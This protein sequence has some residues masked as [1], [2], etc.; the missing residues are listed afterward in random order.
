MKV[1]EI[2]HTGTD[3][4]SVQKKAYDT[5][6]V[7]MR[8]LIPLHYGN[9]S[10][11]ISP[12]TLLILGTFRSKDDYKYEF[13]LGPATPPSPS[14]PKTPARLASLDNLFFPVSLFAP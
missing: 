5:V 12:V 3:S 8:N 6:V 1:N 9:S 13:S 4:S 2:L 11:Q 7:Y 14:L 10:L